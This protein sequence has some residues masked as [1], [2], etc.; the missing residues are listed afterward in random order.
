MNR[1]ISFKTALLVALLVVAVVPV[2]TVGLVARSVQRGDLLHHVGA[3][4]LT[5]ARSVAREVES[6]LRE[7][8]NFIEHIGKVLE[9]DKDLASQ[10]V[11]LAE[12]ISSTGLFESLFLLDRTGRVVNVAL[13]RN[14]KGSAGDYLGMD[15]SRLPIFLETRTTGELSRS[16]VFLSSVSG[17]PAVMF[18]APAGEGVVVGTLGLRVLSDISAHAKPDDKGTVIIV[19]R[20]G[21]VIGHPDYSLVRRQTD[22]GGLDIVREGLAGKAGTHT[23]MVNG[24]SHLGSVVQIPGTGWLVIVEVPL[25]TALAPV[26]EIEII[27]RIATLSTIVLASLLALAGRSVIFRPVTALMASA[28]QIAHGNYDVVPLPRSFREIDEL[29]G[30]FRSMADAVKTRESELKERNEELAMTEEE[31]RQQL[32]EYQ[33]SQD[34]LVESEERYRQLVESAPDAIVIHCEGRYVFANPAAL[35][36]YGADTAAQ[37]LGREITDFVHPDSRQVVAERIKLLYQEH[38]PVPLCEQQ[39]I[40]LDGTVVDVEVVGIPYTHQGKPA[41][42]AVLR[43]ITERK[44]AELRIRQLNA[45]LEERVRERTALLEAANRELESFSYS[46]SHDLRAP[47]RHINGFG[48]A[49]ME[50]CGDVLPDDGK[51]YLERIRS[52]ARRMGQLIDDLLDLSRVSREIMRRERVNL[53]RIGREL[54]RE[55]QESWPERRVSFEIEDGITAEGDPTL[56]RVALANLVDNAWKYT[57]KNEEAHIR[58]GATDIGGTRAI[59][60]SDNGAGFDMRYVDKLFRPFQRLHRAEDFEG[61]GIGLATVLRIVQRHGGRVWAEGEVGKG[62]TVYFT[63]GQSEGGSMEQIPKG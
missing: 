33:S 27:F 48:L 26:N 38:S 16:K 15:F 35:R 53:S 29:G 44:Q 14:A 6:S 31:L 25:A 2:L 34:R 60:V 4:N 56:L 51:M 49:L 20:Y 12:E 57:A 52:A 1:R 54:A 37:L 61:T 47:L 5:L 8:S 10:S 62:A 11:E 30:G 41:V 28:R 13:A 32:D 23:Y 36:L 18:A 22:L 17:D 21:K 9:D 58:V 55:H 42:Q 50:E 3:S 46:V 63:L 45:E 19:S 39:V 59:F 43:E 7:P 40:R 24:E